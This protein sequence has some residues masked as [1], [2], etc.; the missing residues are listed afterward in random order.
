LTP[1]LDPRNFAKLAREIAMDMLELDE[2]QKLH[3]LSDAEFKQV[4]ENP[5]FIEM[6]NGMIGEWNSANNAPARIKMKAQ[7]GIEAAMEVIL[8]DAMSSGIPLNQRV[9]ALKLLAKLGELDEKPGA[10]GSGT[11]G[12]GGVTIQINLAPGHGR[13]E[14]HVV[15]E[16]EFN[17]EAEDVV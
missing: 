2:L 9:E 8:Q 6:L 17:R 3:N 10:L 4:T 16:T 7:T 13:P 12:G 15:I 1:A 11:G 5:R 14:E